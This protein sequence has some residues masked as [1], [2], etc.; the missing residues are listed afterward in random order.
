MRIRY[1]FRVEFGQLPDAT[2]ILETTRML[3]NEFLLNPNRF[4]D[5]Y[6]KWLRPMNSLCPGHFFS[7]NHSE[8][9]KFVNYHRQNC[10][11][12]LEY[13]DLGKNYAKVNFEYPQAVPYKVSNQVNLT[14]LKS[15]KFF[16]YS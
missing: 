13:T 5:K 14:P 4:W 16:I 7:I 15:S 2:T 12:T 1:S 9:F 11:L 8:D 10:S 3:H 6:S